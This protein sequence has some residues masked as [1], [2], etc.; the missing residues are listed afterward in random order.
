[1]TTARAAESLIAVGELSFR[2]KIHREPQWCTSDGWKGLAISVERADVRG[3][4]LLIELPF[5]A[6]ERRSTPQRQRPNVSDAELRVHIA[7]AID[8]GWKPES[9]GKPFLLEVANDA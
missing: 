9:R 6:N 5:S 1:M 4:Q 7:E 8:A 2:W 3:R